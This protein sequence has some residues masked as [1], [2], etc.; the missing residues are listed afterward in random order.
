MRNIGPYSCHLNERYS[1]DEAIGW[2]RFKYA[3]CKISGGT[4]SICTD[5]SVFRTRGHHYDKRFCFWT[6]SFLGHTRTGSKN[7]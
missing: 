3:D 7:K 6:T 4:H 1:P 2:R 5:D